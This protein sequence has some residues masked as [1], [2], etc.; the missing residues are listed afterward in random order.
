MS[1]LKGENS[2]IFEVWRSAMTMSARPA[3]IG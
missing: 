2:A 3:M 1:F